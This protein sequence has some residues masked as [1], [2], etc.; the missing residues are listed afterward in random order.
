VYV[1]DLYVYVG[2]SMR[3]LISLLSRVCPLS[4]DDVDSCMTYGEFFKAFSELADR[5]DA[6][7][8]ARADTV[9]PHQP[10]LYPKLDVSQHRRV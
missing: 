5:K 8:Y 10:D 6:T 1:G 4:Q 2:H 7:L 3:V 9:F